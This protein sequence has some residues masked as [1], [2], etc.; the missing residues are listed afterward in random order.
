MPTCQ[1]VECVY[2]DYYGADTTTITSFGRRR[3][4][5]SPLLPPS[6]FA[7]QARS[8]Q[9]DLAAPAS[10]NKNDLLVT[11]VRSRRGA[12]DVSSASQ[13]NHGFFLIS[14]RPSWWWTSSASPGPRAPRLPQP[15][16]SDSSKCIPQRAREAPPG[17]RPPPLLTARGTANSGY[18][19]PVD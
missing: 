11:Q 1:P 16:N 5:R 3:R 10:S 18:I 15:R 7:R 17:R 6:P 4:K 13:F 14:S 8:Y 2:S 19:V 12:A 9:V